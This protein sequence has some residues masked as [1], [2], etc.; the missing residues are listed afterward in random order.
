MTK[1]SGNKGEWSE[2][3]VF[4]RLLEVGKLYAAT[5]NLE[6]IDTVFYNVLKIIRN[7]DIGTLE[8]IFNKETNTISIL[9]TSSGIILLS[10]DTI[11]FKNEADKL[12]KAIVSSKGSS[13]SVDKTEIFLKNIGIN[14]LKAKSS[15]KSDIRI[16]IH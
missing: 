2:I 11:D 4:L 1:L 3:Y 8:F 14:K 5:E 12:Y 15:D 7:E 13:F 16:K 9:N 6:K 10:L